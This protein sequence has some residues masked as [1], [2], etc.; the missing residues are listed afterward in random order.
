[1]LLIIDGNNMAH[2]ARYSFELSFHG[3]DVSVTYGMLR[4]MLAVVKEQKPEAV[5]VCFDGGYPGFRKRLVPS[6]KEHRTHTKDPT[7]PEFLRQMDELDKV[8]PMFGVMVVRRRGIEADDLMYQASRMS[9]HKQSLIVTNDDDLLQAVNHN[10]SVL[11]PVTKKEDLV[12]TPSNF[13]DVTGVCPGC[14]MCA[15]VLQGDVGDGVPGCHGV[16]PKTIG[17]LFAGIECEPE[18]WWGLESRVNPNMAIRI[19]SFLGSGAYEKAWDAMDLSYDRSGARLALSE[20]SWL[21]YQ[22]KSVYRYCVDNAFMSL[23]EAS[24]LRPVFGSLG[25]PEMSVKVGMRVPRV[26]DTYRS[27]V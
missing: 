14:F 15:K 26:W 16:G 21:P 18:W 3:K 7:Y 1:M 12:V 8:L 5:L 25:R 2:R 13:R 22:D 11:K 23:I 17:K 27:P 19:N 9:N 4:M 20:A 24:P 10:T 6:Y